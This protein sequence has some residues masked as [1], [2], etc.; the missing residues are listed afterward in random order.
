VRESE[1]ATQNPVVTETKD[2]KSEAYKIVDF[3]VIWSMI[4]DVAPVAELADAVD[5]KST[6]LTEVGV[7]PS[8]GAP[9]NILKIIQ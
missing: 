5:S 3:W 9:P 6:F 2:L 1:E 7:R 8:P 4:R